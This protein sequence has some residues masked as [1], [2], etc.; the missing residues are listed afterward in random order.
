MEKQHDVL[1]WNHENQLYME[2]SQMNENGQFLHMLEPQG[3]SLLLFQDD[4]GSQGTSHS[5]GHVS[6]HTVTLSG[7]EEFEE[8]VDSPSSVNALRSC[9]E[10]ESFGS[11]GEGNN[12]HVA[13]EEPQAASLN[14]GGVLLHQQS[15]ESSNSFG[16]D[17]HFLP[18]IQFIEHE[19]V[20]LDSLNVHSED[21]YPHVDFDT[22]DSGFGECS[23]PG[24]SD[25]N[26]AEQIVSDSF[27]E[28]KGLNSNYV[29]QWTVCNT[30]QQV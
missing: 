18:H 5:T 15:P 24:A 26:R 11:F 14:R 21:G 23:S 10:A 22:F 2:S 20:S 25:S 28:P 12:E 3:N 16:E 29:K 8:E 1:H 9:Q 4:S 17:I 13:C 19:R 27:P 6:I 7:E 30:V